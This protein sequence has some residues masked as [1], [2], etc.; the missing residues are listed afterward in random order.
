MVLC[1][2]YYSPM[3]WNG[4]KLQRDNIHWKVF[5]IYLNIWIIY[6]LNLDREVRSIDF[7][8]H[9]IRIYRI[10]D[11][12]NCVLPIGGLNVSR[13]FA[14]TL[15]TSYGLSCWDWECSIYEMKSIHFISVQFPFPSIGV[16]FSVLSFNFSQRWPSHALLSFPQSFFHFNI[17]KKI[18]PAIDSH[19]SLPNL[20]LYQF[21]E[22]PNVWSKSPIFGG[23]SKTMVIIKPA[24]LNHYL[25]MKN[26]FRF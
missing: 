1:W 3:A 26:I 16:Q 7:T 18:K 13:K 8:N 5:M 10:C 22:P 24:T 20:R 23:H 21:Y 12:Q 2:L 25:I 15:W 9:V 11:I 4:S 17:Q 6:L 14:R 19:K